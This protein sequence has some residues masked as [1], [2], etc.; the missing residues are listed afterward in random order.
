MVRLLLKWGLLA[1]ALLFLTHILPGIRVNSFG[2]ALLAA[3]IIGLLNSILRPVLIILTLPVTVVTMGLFLLVINA[4]L[5][6][7][8]GKMLSGF[9]VGGFW[10]AMLGAIAY[11]LLGMLIDSAIEQLFGRRKGY[12]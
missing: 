3:A 4:L 12:N 7:W 6:W 2:S 1:T 9:A 8:A 11:S 5:F 10:W